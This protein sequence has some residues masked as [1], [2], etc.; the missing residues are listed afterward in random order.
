MFT[1]FIEKSTVITRVRMV[2]AYKT[3]KNSLKKYEKCPE[4]FKK[5]S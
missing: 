4:K 1:W 3:H 5:L 2:I